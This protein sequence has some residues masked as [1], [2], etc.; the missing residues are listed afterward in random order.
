MHFVVPWL[1][2]LSLAAMEQHENG[3]RQHEAWPPRSRLDTP[4]APVFP[5]YPQRNRLR[6]PT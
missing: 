5:S 4:L 6:L 2:N 3:A 1:V